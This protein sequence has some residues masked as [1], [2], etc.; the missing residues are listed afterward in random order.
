MINGGLGLLLAYDAPLSFAPT[1]GQ[2]IAYG[3]V[4]AIMWLLY[5]TAAIIGERRRSIAGKE[6]DDETGKRVDESSPASSRAP[7][8][9]RYR[10]VNERNRCVKS[11]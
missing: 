6:I 1:R 10:Y 7:H 5:V 11:C 3:V 4:T 8:K 9:E 2:V